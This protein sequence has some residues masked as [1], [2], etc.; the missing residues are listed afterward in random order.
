MLIRKREVFMIGLIFLII[1]FMLGAMILVYATIDKCV[2]IGIKIL[3]LNKIE[4]NV[5]KDIII[6]AI[7]SH[8]GALGTW[9][10]ITE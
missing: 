4:V 9:L 10:N 1:G 6:G 3:K 2:E 5:N 7:T 8:K